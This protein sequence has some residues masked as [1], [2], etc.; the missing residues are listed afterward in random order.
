M[1]YYQDGHDKG[2]E[3]G[4]EDNNNLRGVGAYIMDAFL[5]TSEAEDEWNQGYEDGY[6]EGKAERESQ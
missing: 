3:D 1:S 6:A 4:L 5:P 2:H